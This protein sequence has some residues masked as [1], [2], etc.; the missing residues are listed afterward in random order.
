MAEKKPK[1]L[2]RQTIKNVNRVRTIITLVISL[3]SAAQYLIPIFLVV[4]G[5]GF[6]AIMIGSAALA[7]SVAQG[8]P[9]TSSTTSGGT[10]GTGKQVTPDAGS[11]ASYNAHKDIYDVISKYVVPPLTAKDARIT[12]DIGAR[13]LQTGSDYHTGVDMST[14][15]DDQDDIVAIMDG[16]VIRAGESSGYGYAIYIRHD[17]KDDASGKT[18]TV[19]SIYGHMHKSSIA[20]K[21]GDDVKAGQKLAKIGNEGGSEGAHLHLDLRLPTDP[22]PVAWDSSI[23]ASYKSPDSKHNYLL[24]VIMALSGKSATQG[25][26][27]NLYEYIGR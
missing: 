16:K 11:V 5:G 7:G 21:T 18:I 8:L 3:A 10:S 4:I 24:D 23:Q 2:T 13:T 22:S 9:T 25:Q 17:I 1:S 20:V 12:S 15:R 19:Y 27:K 26:G 14:R 6:I